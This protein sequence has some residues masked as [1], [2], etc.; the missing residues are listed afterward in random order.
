MFTFRSYFLVSLFG[1][2]SLFWYSCS[3]KE[4][5]KP[6][7]TVP[8]LA[9]TTAATSI[10]ETT[11]SSGG[12]VTEDGGS[13]ILARGIC[14]DTLAS[15]TFDND[16]P[17]T[18]DGA[19]T[20]SFTSTL[21]DLLPGKKYFVRA[22]AT[23][24]I[25]IGY[26]AEISFTTTELAAPKLTTTAVSSILDSSA[27]TGGN[28]TDDVGVP[29]VERGVC[30]S[31]TTLSPTV[32][33]NFKA[34]S[35]AGAGE[36][37][38]SLSGLSPLT[39]YNIR[40]YAKNTKG[41]IGYGS[42]LQFTTLGRP[43]VATG[44]VTNTTP[45]SATCSGT[46]TSNG[47]A[48]QSITSKGIQFSTSS[49]S[50][51]SGINLPGSGP[52]SGFTSNLTNLTPNTQYFYRAYATN[53]SGLTGYSVI[54]SFTTSAT[55]LPTLSTESVAEVFLVANSALYQAKVTGNLSSLNGGTF[56]KKGFVWSLTNPEPTLASNDG[57]A[58]VAGGV[59]GNFTASF[60]N[61]PR[62]KSLNVRAFATTSFSGVEV[63][64][65]GASK[66]LETFLRDL[67]GNLYNMVKIGSQ[68]WMKENLK[69]TRLRDGFT[70]PNV[71]GN[72][73][74]T[75]N[76]PGFC[77]Y[78]NLPSNKDIYGLLYNFYTVTDPR[79]LCPAGWHTA[80]NGDWNSM[81]GF[82]GGNT[83]AGGKMKTTSSI[84][85]SPNAG[86]TDES[87]FSGLPGGERA[88]FYSG[89]GQKAYF[90]S[91]PGS[92]ASGWFMNLSNANAQTF[93]STTSSFAG[94]SVRCVKD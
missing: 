44:A 17:F 57:M 63:T 18:S 28:I 31:V 77:V 66:P 22:F 34:A 6:P 93:Q 79:G 82:L 14:Y 1:L 5:S 53:S 70:M 11:A 59:L 27:T 69:V 56:V 19:G 91:D 16:H 61:L 2:A 78:D 42:T 80:T 75:W 48:G 24:V 72:G 45:T 52:E 37:S 85:A 89:I 83:V 41:A 81:V 73:W 43:V 21:T 8:V 9:A 7:V 71:T 23:N 94:N 30:W 46:V 10:T 60:N 4:E 15:P 62:L 38:V 36:F 67:D 88:T 12:N 86:A 25:G 87:G 65:Y 49:S 26:G 84:W 64:G 74:S 39:I 68:V 54:E 47:G 20:G 92:S 33:D 90:W 58:E 50:I 55:V 76:F 51:G 29:V 13:T 3:K 32:S 35:G 40:A